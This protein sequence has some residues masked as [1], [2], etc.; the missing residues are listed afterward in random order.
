MGVNQNFE[1][2]TQKNFQKSQFGHF[3]PFQ[4]LF[5][6]SR[7]FFW[8][9]PSSPA[10]KSFIPAQI[11]HLPARLQIPQEGV[12]RLAGRRLVGWAPW[13]QGGVR[14]K[15]VPPANHK[16]DALWQLKS[17]KEIFDPIVFSGKQEPQSANMALL[18]PLL[19]TP[20]VVAARASLSDPPGS[21]TGNLRLAGKAAG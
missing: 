16:K 18:E 13:G 5:S 17:K 9:S 6:A 11:L 1:I 21:E 8:S 14:L 10:A 3:G 7:E 20:A 4:K 19:A 2:K 15:K 12:H